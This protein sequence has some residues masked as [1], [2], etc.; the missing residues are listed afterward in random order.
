MDPVKLFSIISLISLPTVIFGGYSL[1][2]LLKS[3]KLTASQV[4]FFRAG[5]AHAG[6]L[7]VM[8]LSYYTF[9]RQTAIGD[10]GTWLACILLMIGILAQSGGFFIQLIPFKSEKNMLG[11]YVT[12]AGAVLLAFD[13]LYLAYGLIVA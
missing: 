2:R 1:L 11:M 4:T 9:L 6:V 12:T 7:L 5:H 13:L 10:F 8:S 3:R